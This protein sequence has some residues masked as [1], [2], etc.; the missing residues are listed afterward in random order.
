MR[1]VVKIGSQLLT[2]EDN[3][4][5]TDFIG[6]IAAQIAHLYEQGHEPLLV[7]SGAVAAGRNTICIRKETKTIPYRQALAAVGQTFLLDTYRDRFSKYGIVIGQVLL[8]MVDFKQHGHFLSTYNT[9]ELLLKLRVVPIINENDVTTFNET[10]F[11][12]NDKLSAHVASMMGA[13]H[14]IMLTDVEGFYDNNPKEVPD[15]KLIPIVEQLTP[16]MKAAAKPSGSKKSIGGMWEKVLGAEY[17]NASG[18]N[19]WIARGTIPNVITDI[20]EGEKHHGTLFKASVSRQNARR[21]WLQT[22]LLKNTSI[23]VD[24]GAKKAILDQGKSLLPSGIRS[25]EGTFRRGDVVTL[26]GPQGERV[27]FGQANYPS[28]AV[29]AIKGKHSRDIEKVLGYSLEDEVMNRDNLV[30]A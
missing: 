24:E 28:E 12:N 7:T 23:T 29:E 16:A 17:A 10:K 22:R 2:N 19:V 6:K 5:N 3:S 15:A 14:L 8:T 26:L 21:R 11:G 20:L 27:G 18:V 1:F 4:L 13:E 30:V 9:I 25:I